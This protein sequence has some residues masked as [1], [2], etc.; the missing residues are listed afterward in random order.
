MI[1]K[2]NIK[3][4][5][6]HKDSELEFIKGINVIIGSSDAGKSAI[7]RTIRWLLFNRPLG[8]SFV[9]KG[10]K[11]C[12]VKLETENGTAKRIKGKDSFYEINDSV[13]RSV[14]TDV[15]DTIND[16]L[17]ISDIN[18]QRQLDRHFLVLGTGGEIAA[19][20]NEVLKIDEIDSSIS[21]CAKKIR[22][23]DKEVHYYRDSMK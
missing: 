2:L 13:Y 11:E 6:S 10:E 4:Y 20:L 12:S 18:L 21:H 22:N 17:C 8:E 19:K 5:Q 16:V 9:R 15:P 1:N 3:N 14:G 7:I 23:L